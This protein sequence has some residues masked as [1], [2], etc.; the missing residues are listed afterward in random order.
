MVRSLSA[1]RAFSF[2]VILLLVVGLA[3]SQPANDQKRSAGKAAFDEAI[4][5]RQENTYHS[6]QQALEKFRLSEKL[7]E[8]IDDQPN[9][10]S[11]LIGQGL[12]LNLINEKDEALRLYFRALSI[13]R[14]AR[15]SSLEARTLN[16]IGL[17]YDELGRKR[18]AIEF[19][20]LALPLRRTI[21]DRYGEAN[22]LNSLGSAY[23]DIGEM[24]LA[25]D[26]FNRALAVQTEI[27]D[28]RA[29]AITHSN[30]GRLYSQ[31]GDKQK[32]VE[33][34]ERSLNLRRAIGDRAGEA[35]T[36]NNLGMA[37]IDSGDAARAIGLYDDSLAI[38]SELG[39]E[40]RK[41]SVLNNIA[42]AYIALGDYDK[43]AK[44]SRMA[45]PLY[46]AATDPSG[47]AT[48]L[49]NIALAASGAGNG[50][51][52]IEHL[53][54]ALIL[55]RSS[56]SRGLE[57]IILGN[58]MR[59]SVQLRRPAI[60][61]VFGKQCI[62]V[63]Q[64][65]R[66]NIR[67]LDTATQRAYLNTI[68]DN[69][70]YLVD[71]LTE[72]GRFSEATSVLG[73]LK[74]E[75]YSAFVRRDAVEAKD[76]ATRPV[77]TRSE[78]SLIRRYTEL[79]SRVGAAGRELRTIDEKRRKL[80]V[81]DE[82]LKPADEKRR[83]T[84]TSQ[85]ED[86][87]SNLRLFLEKNLIGEIGTYNSRL[88]ERDRALQEKLR[89]WGDGTVALY[90]VIT[91]NRYRIILTTSSSQFAAKTDI[92]AAELNKKIFAFRRSLQ[93]TATDPLPL[94]K[95]LYDILLK[96]IESELAAA[97]AHTLIW[98]LDGMLRYI[99]IAALSPDGK[100]YLVER[101]SAAILT[102]YGRD[103]LI[104]SSG[105]PRALG[106]GV[107]KEQSVVFPDTPENKIKI[108]ALPGALEELNSIIRDERSTLFTGIVNGR[109]Y[110]DEE[111]TLSNF[112]TSLSSNTRSRRRF[113]LVHLA[114][115]FRLGNSWST[116]YLI[117]GNG[118][119]LSL[120]KISKTA[121]IDF[122]GVDLI[123]LSACNTALGTS[124]G[125]EVDSLAGTIE[126]KS[127]RAVLAS[128]WEVSDKSTARL[129]TNFY[130]SRKELKLTK[131]EALRHA[132]RDLIREGPELTHPYFW[133]GFVLSG[134][135]R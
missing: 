33:Y 54:D 82:K 26:H 45:L 20:T 108:E 135:W 133:S 117:L 59:V 112:V 87:G 134:N 76:I 9:V 38:L 74:D 89:Q 129:M 37:V 72:L 34:L 47:E 7:Y 131:A 46:R 30:L 16:N 27:D 83:K 70:R 55:A 106:F 66:L 79:A 69:Y 127:G 52:A 113:G 86:A 93:D 35:T 61:I 100:T 62:G 17:L 21:G 119:L 99:P 115:H 1:G 114:S 13:F 25:L 36:L 102:P 31:L 116:S 94:G 80:A 97:G 11:A 107:S 91:E 121:A 15:V 10:G 73:L 41:A 39:F 19:H 103:H 29:Q 2:V 65:L 3:L 51:G 32:A 85:L 96:P 23:T 24:A 122:T 90:T 6:Y 8:E 4:R 98:S 5:L 57:A 110:L 111:F 126:R 77:F 75:E 88:I 71:L 14:S 104:E 56:T 132:Q 124:N 43:A 63:Y 120:E 95:E 53:S 130:K 22:T 67:E 49:N 128:L 78:Q 18:K 58:L 118:E 40:N 123:T 12:I 109:L 42:A 44:F 48:A 50:Q 81:R 101:Y 68:E 60:A 125:R 28:K 84:L 105:S 64:E 92:S